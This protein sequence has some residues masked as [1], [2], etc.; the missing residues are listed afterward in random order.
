[1]SADS[2]NTITAVDVELVVAVDDTETTVW[3]SPACAPIECEC[4]QGF[5]I[6]VGMSNMHAIVKVEGK[7]GT[8]FSIVTELVRCT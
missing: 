5:P 4:S 1:M 7:Y 2:D 3:K 8:K 6:E